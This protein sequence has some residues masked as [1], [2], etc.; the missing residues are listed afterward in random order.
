L[1]IGEVDAAFRGAR[2][3]AG[4]SVNGFN[5]SKDHMQVDHGP[6]MCRVLGDM[7]LLCLDGVVRL[8]PGIPAGVPAR[9][10]SLRAPGGFLISA[11][12]RGAE[13]DYALIEPTMSGRLRLA[14]PWSDTACVIDRGSGI[15]VGSTA[16][17]VLAVQLEAGHSYLVARDGFSPDRL[18]MIDFSDVRGAEKQAMD[19]GYQQ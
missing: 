18:P 3:D 6:G 9:F 11:E 14:N 1:R 17:K 16:G 15:K 13:P 2:F 10:F 12:K 4:R 7:L 8:F 19:S 5:V